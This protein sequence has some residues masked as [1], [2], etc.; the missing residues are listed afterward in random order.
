MFSTSAIL[1]IAVSAAIISTAVACGADQAAPARDTAP[2]SASANAGP[3]TPAPGGKYIEVDMITDGEGSYYKPSEVHANRGD[4]IRFKL[5]IGVHNTHFP[6]DSNAGKS[7]MPSG[8]GE[9][10]QLPGQTY[11]VAVGMEPGSYF[12]QCDPHVALGMKGRLIVH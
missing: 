6:A 11:D 8:P 4:V 5:K 3:A 2:A 1:R 9:F 7:G 10:L 12:F